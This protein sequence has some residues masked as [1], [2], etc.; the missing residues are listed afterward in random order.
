MEEIWKTIKGHPNYEV[1]IDGRIRKKEVLLTYRTGA[2]RLHKQRMLKPDSSHMDY[3]RVTFSQ[4]NKQKRLSVHRVVAEHFLSRIPGKDFVN[5][6]DGNRLNN[7]ANNLEWC[8]SSENELHSYR[9]LGKVNPIRKLTDEQASEIRTK[10]GSIP[11]RALAAMYGVNKKTV[12]NIWNNVY[13]IKA[14][15]TGGC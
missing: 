3:C 15:P 6:K 1:C 14:V 4:G 8:T 13:Y 2:N 10:K 9:V 7:H 11:S 12:L 5:H